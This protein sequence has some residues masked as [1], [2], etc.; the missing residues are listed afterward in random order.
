MNETLRVYYRVTSFRKNCSKI[1]YSTKGLLRSKN[2]DSTSPKFHSSIK[3][4]SR[5]DFYFFVTFLGLRYLTYKE[6]GVPNQS[7]LQQKIQKKQRIKQIKITRK[8][9]KRQQIRKNQQRKQL[10]RKKQQKSQ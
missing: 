4:R 3:N 5:L 6:R 8:K 1:Y 7:S 10:L 9:Q 2:G